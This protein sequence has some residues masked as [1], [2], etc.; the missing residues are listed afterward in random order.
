MQTET[1]DRTWQGLEELRGVLACYLRR[2]TSDDHEIDDVIQETFVRAAH[3]RGRLSEPQ[4]LKAWTLRIA[5]N[6][7]ADQRRR[8]LRQGLERE[9]SPRGLDG[10]E[11]PSDEAGEEWIRVGTEVHDRDLVLAELRE[12]LA[13][14][15]TGDRRLLDAFYGGSQSC[16]E[17]AG[18]CGVPRHL[19][20][21]RLFRARQRLARAM[22]RRIAR[23]M[24]VLAPLSS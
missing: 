17:T 7:L 12:A 19:V 21:V 4:R 13:G 14:L 3:Y 24:R 22:R 15:R 9:G 2:H 18:A 10:F 5:R 6:V 16:Q 23:R 20:K 11:D 1:A 8:E